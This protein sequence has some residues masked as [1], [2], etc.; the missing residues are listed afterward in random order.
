MADIRPQLRARSATEIVDAAF[1]LFRRDPLTYVL[2]AAVGYVPLL[3]LQLV[4]LGPASQIEAQ[5]ARITAG[6]G[7]VML[8]GYWV[9]LSL[10]S[11]VIVRLS[12]E[13]YLGRPLEPS[14]AVRQAL[15]RLPA[16]M[17]GLLL[18]YIMML[19][20]FLLFFV[21]VLW[22]VARYFAV[23]PAVVLEGR[24]AF[25]ALSRSVALSR[26]QKMHILGT[27]MLA[28]LIFFVVY[29][30]VAIIGAAT[31]S[32][33]I[34]TVLTTAASIVAYPMFAITEM[35]LYY[36]ARVRNEGYDIELM[37]DGLGDMAPVTE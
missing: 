10:M 28:F 14:A 34:T 8:L 11:A 24:G 7:V 21:G 31:A 25:G 23:T 22:M 5:I 2:V 12:S 29:F 37:T 20:G 30:A 19:L 13:N 26:G 35:L 16:V 27:S 36:D 33:V 1:Q 9:S 17:G 4:V 6:Y 18:K 3:I 32:N 15:A